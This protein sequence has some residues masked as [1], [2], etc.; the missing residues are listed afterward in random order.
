M[1]KWIDSSAIRK[2]KKDE[3]MLRSCAKRSGKKIDGFQH[4]NHGNGEVTTFPRYKKA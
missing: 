3:R 1:S 4:V 2:I